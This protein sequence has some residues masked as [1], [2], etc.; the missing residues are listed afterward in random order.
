MNVKRFTART[1]RD[2]LILVRQALGED[3]VVLSTKPSVDGVEVLAMA[4]E[5]M[6]QIERMAATPE[7][8]ASKPVEEDV[9]RR[10]FSLPAAMGSRVPREG[11][12]SPLDRLT[13]EQQQR[14]QA[15]ISS[16]NGE[17][18]EAEADK[19][20]GWAD[21]LKLGLEREIKELD[22]QIKDARKG[23]TGAVS[24]E[25]KLTAQKR[26]KAIES[27]RNHK[28]RSLFDAQDEIDRKRGE[29]IAQIEGKLTQKVHSECLFTIRWRVV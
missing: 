28:R 12:T 25:A 29:L 13:S 24:L 15:R 18:F 6:K 8:L 3:A 20:D 2:A 16:R 17:L 9:A 26:M 5:S 11:D 1:S 14:I 19:L 21:D 23:A 4:P 22:K 27:E 7:P 10:L